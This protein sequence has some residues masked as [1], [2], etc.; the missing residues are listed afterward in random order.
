MVPGKNF[1]ALVMVVLLCGVLLASELPE[2]LKA[3][4]PQLVSVGSATLRWFGIHVYDMSL[5]T[6]DQKYTPESTAV[7]SILYHISIKHRR[8]QD[9][10]LEEWQRMNK[11]TPEQ[12]EAWIQQ[13]DAMWPDIKSGESLSAYRQSE[14]PTQFYFGDRLLGEVADPEF[15]PAFFAIWL[16]ADCRYPKLRD[17]ILKTDK[18]TNNQG[19]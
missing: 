16:D 14:G 6:T 13:L 17:K 15:G 9:T 4:R 18:K 8:L 19:Q 5:Y 12:Q 7:L 10:T 2:P 1:I 11:G 3:V